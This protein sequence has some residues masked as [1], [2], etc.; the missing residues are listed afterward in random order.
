MT[1][2]N[3]LEVE[4]EV[5]RF[6]LRLFAIKQRIKDDKYALMGCKE[7]GALK[8]AALDLKIELTKLTR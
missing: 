4:K 7:S 1:E 6:Q 8:R 5:E 2:Q 3:I